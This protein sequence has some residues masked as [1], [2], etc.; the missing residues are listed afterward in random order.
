MTDL[1]KLKKRWETFGNA[2]KSCWMKVREAKLP[3]AEKKF[4]YFLDCM[5]VVPEK[6]KTP[7]AKI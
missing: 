1:T 4:E 2:S 6:V 7:E 5:R 3:T